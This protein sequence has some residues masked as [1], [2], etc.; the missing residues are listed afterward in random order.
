[1]PPVSFHPLFKDN[2]DNPL[3]RIRVDRAL[4]ERLSASFEAMRP[5]ADALAAAFYR[6]LFERRP[7][8][9]PLFQTPLS[10][11]QR[12]LIAS[13]ETIVRYLDDPPSQRAYLRELGRRHKEYGAQ[14][15]HYDLVIETLIE[16]MV[17]A[18]PGAMEPAIRDE[19]RQVLRLVSDWMI[20]GAEDL[21][22]AEGT[23]G[24]RTRH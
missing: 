19:W 22:F 2:P 6:R 23:V 11:Q 4:V 8:L 15:A 5:A 21:P 24:P 18:A 13:L 7:D 10:V 3:P 16:A 14:P 1:M 17:E 20:S 12:K 9:R